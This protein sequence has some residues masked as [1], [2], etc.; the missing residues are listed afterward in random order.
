MNRKKIER[1]L[2]KHYLCDFIIYAGIMTAF[3]TWLLWD[4]DAMLLVLSIIAAV[5]PGALVCVIL[6]LIRKHR[7]FDRPLPWLD[8]SP[9]ERLTKD[10]CLS[11]D[12]LVYYDRLKYWFVRRN[13]VTDITTT[14]GNG[15]KQAVFTLKRRS[16]LPFSYIYEPAKQPDLY[17]RIAH[18]TQLEKTCPYCGAVNPADAVFCGNCGKDL[19]GAKPMPAKKDTGAIAAMV[20]LTAMFILLICFRSRFG[21]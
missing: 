2:A 1:Q 21:L 19:G 16:G 13:E 10:L 9:F 3:F 14:E 4:S 6:Y 8:N 18:W 17:E 5:L 20:I 15:R 11:N 12:Y 7:T